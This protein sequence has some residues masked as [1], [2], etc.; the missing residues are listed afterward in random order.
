MYCSRLLVW[1]P[2]SWGWT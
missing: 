1:V 2:K